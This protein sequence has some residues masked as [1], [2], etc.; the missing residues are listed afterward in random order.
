MTVVLNSAQAAI[1][2][3]RY[4]GA[5][6]KGSKLMVKERDGMAYLEIRDLAGF[7]GAGSG[8]PSG[9]GGGGDGVE[10]REEALM[11]I[12]RMKAL[13]ESTVYLMRPLNGHDVQ[14]L[15]YFFVFI[16][17]VESGVG[18]GDM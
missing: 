2:P 9:E 3:R 12:S 5:Y 4:S 7:P 1:R 15:D 13:S 11:A 6:R 17:F 18:S 10:A 8:I 14:D 16:D